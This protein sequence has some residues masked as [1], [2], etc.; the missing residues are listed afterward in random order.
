MNPQGN[1]SIRRLID[2]WLDRFDDT[3]FYK[4]DWDDLANAIA[5]EVQRIIGTKGPIFLTDKIP[6]FSNLEEYS[7]HIVKVREQLRREQRA[8]A[9]MEDGENE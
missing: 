4:G 7:E 6:T 2:D 1:A 5:A 8:R 9:G 3:Y